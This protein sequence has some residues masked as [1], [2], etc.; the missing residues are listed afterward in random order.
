MDASDPCCV[1]CAAKASRFCLFS[2][3]KKHCAQTVDPT[4]CGYHGTK[5][6]D[7][8][9]RILNPVF[10]YEHDSKLKRVELSNPVMDIGREGILTPSVGAAFWV[11]CMFCGKPLAWDHTYWNH[12][13]RCNPRLFTM[14]PHLIDYPINQRRDAII[15]LCQ[16]EQVSQVFFQ[17]SSEEPHGI[18][19]LLLLK[20]C[21]CM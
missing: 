7:L 14:Y 18:F 5:Q 13:Q 17:N 10:K 11:Q 8:P 15:K 4:I 19:Y 12:L 21:R 3:C 2:L 1:K 9:R 6:R 16:A 20:Y